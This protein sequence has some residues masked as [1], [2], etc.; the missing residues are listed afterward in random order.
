MQQLLAMRGVGMELVEMVVGQEEGEGVC[1]EERRRRFMENQMDILRRSRRRTTRRRANR[2]I[3]IMGVGV[4]VDME[5]A[6]DDDN[7]S[8]SRA[9][10][11]RV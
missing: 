8:P 1:M 7:I 4:G 2:G 9:F 6:R 10:P 11:V 5:G 3:M